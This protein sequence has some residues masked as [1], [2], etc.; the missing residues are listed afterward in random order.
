MRYYGAFHPSALYPLAQENQ[1]LPGAVAQ[2][3]VPQTAGQLGHNHAEVVHRRQESAKLLRALGLGYRAWPRVVTPE[4]QEPYD[5]R[6]SRTVLWEPGDHGPRAT[7][8]R[9]GTTVTEHLRGHQ[10]RRRPLSHLLNVPMVQGIKIR[11]LL[12]ARPTP[13]TDGH[14]EGGAGHP[15]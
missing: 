14:Q 1:L 7:R 12:L 11:V 13:V 15:D 8:L 3:K 6:L 9:Q 2:G 5:G 4:R 10:P